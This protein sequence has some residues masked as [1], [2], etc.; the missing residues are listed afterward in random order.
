MTC[1]TARFMK[2]PSSLLE[3]DGEIPETC[4]LK[5]RAVRACVPVRSVELGQERPAEIAEGSLLF[6]RLCYKVVCPL[7]RRVR[8]RYGYR[9]FR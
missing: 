8:R 5:S 2:P 4:T 1:A 7:T 9:S 3:R 6:D